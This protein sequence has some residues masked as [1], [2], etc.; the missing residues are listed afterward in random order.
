LA[1]GSDVEPLTGIQVA[2]IPAFGYIALL[3]VVEGATTT[4]VVRYIGGFNLSGNSLLGVLLELGS[5]DVV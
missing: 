1:V 5:V 4:S 3:P 2:L